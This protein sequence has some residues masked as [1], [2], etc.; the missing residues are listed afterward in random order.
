MAGDLKGNLERVERRLLREHRLGK[1]KRK[2][3]GGGSWEKV[4]EKLSQR[5]V[6]GGR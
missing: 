1:R 6:T 4:A 3:H 5:K 2:E